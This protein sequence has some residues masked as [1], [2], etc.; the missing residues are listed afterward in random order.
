MQVL[1]R[2]VFV[3]VLLSV[4]TTSLGNAEE[5]SFGQ[6]WNALKKDFGTL[7]G[8]ITG[9][10]PAQSGGAPPAPAGADRATGE[11]IA[12]HV[13]VQVA[14]AQ[15]LLNQL[16]YSAGPVDGAYGGATR[17]AIARFQAQNGL[18]VT[19]NVTPSL[20]A[21]LQQAV[22]AGGPAVAGAGAPVAAGGPADADAGAPLPG[23]SAGAAD[24]PRYDG[25]WVR[26]V[27]S[28]LTSLGYQPGPV[29]GQFGSRT[30]DAVAAFQRAAGLAADGAPR[31]SLMAALRGR[32]QGSAPTP[33][34]AAAAQASFE[35]APD[36][37]YRTLL[38]LLMAGNP[39]AFDNQEFAL[40]YT[41]LQLPPSRDRQCQQF[42]NALANEISRQGLIAEARARLQEALAAAAQAPDD[43]VFRIV[44]SERAGEYE[45]ERGGFPIVA[46]PSSSFGGNWRLHAQP[47]SA[48]C[49][50]SAGRNFFGAY[51]NHRIEVPI[52]LASAEPLLAM[53][54]DRAQAFLDRN[55]VRS[56]QVEWLIEVAAGSGGLSG[57]AV[58]ARARDSRSAAILHEFDPALLQPAGGEPAA[59]A[60]LAPRLTSWAAAQHALRGLPELLDREQ[61]IELTRIQ[62]IADQQALE[63]GYSSG[64]RD[65]I[66]VFVAEQIQGRLPELAAEDLASTYRQY[67]LQLAAD[68]PNRLR[69]EHGLGQLVYDSAAGMLRCCGSYRQ[70]SLELLL[71]L[72]AGGGVPHG[73]PAA[74]AERALYQ[75]GR[76]IQD[77]NQGPSVGIRNGI[78]RG[79]LP[80]VSML[81][82][83]R[84]LELPGIPLERDRAE[85][86]LLELR[87]GHSSGA[88]DAV[89]EFTIEDVRRDR[90]WQPGVTPLGALAVRLDRVI[91]RMPDGRE[92]ARF[93][94]E[95]FPLARP[96]EAAVAAASP[97]AAPAPAVKS[98]PTQRVEGPAAQEGA[99]AAAASAGSWPPGAAFGVVSRAGED[100]MT[101]LA[102]VK[103]GLD[104]ATAQEI[105]NER[106][107]RVVPLPENEAVR[108]VEL[109]RS[110]GLLVSAAQFDR[111]GLAGREDLRIVPVGA[112]GAAEVGAA[113][114][115]EVAALEAPAPA[116]Q[117]D[118]RAASAFEI[119]GLT[120]G[121]AEADALAALGAEF[122][123]DQILRDEGG[124]ALA[125]ERGACG[126]A[127]PADPAL[128]QETGSFCVTLQIAEG[129][130]AGVVLRQ[131]VAADVAAPALAA[132]RER[133]G[134]PV[135]VDESA[136]APGVS[137]TVLGW[138]A[139]ANAPRIE[140][141]RVDL[142]APATVLEANVWSAHGVTLAVLRLD[143]AQEAAPEPPVAQGIKF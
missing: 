103:N 99:A 98:P 85:Q 22:A 31:P 11:A 138:G 130:V 69:A 24:E 51:S 100:A 23:A 106:G 16:G 5:F 15:D 88:L 101:A 136:P 113:V 66:P 6:A 61:L 21:A 95:A 42:G 81:A 45:F 12:N 65:A 49:R 96:A 34:V 139:P 129:V 73:T 62:V 117:P 48:V 118:E 78:Q 127:E 38:A 86:L 140:L 36:P 13:P 80:G 60:S 14:R 67:L 110:Y 58:A 124:A 17:T 32:T 41:S 37:D 29:D 87:K 134:E 54:P 52:P 104:P 9:D 64:S 18:P 132:L 107:L 120:V 70:E 89:V 137:R 109:L 91:I 135:L 57:R 43:R 114:A 68:A 121:M 8:T 46:D 53:A 59:V 71:P 33:A 97:G 119:L 125:A 56:F 3:A 123:A 25:E 39:E 131:V 141:A 2:S 47:G 7:K 55:P 1:L 84:R 63:P 90:P 126:R 50:V 77:D 40:Y 93:E 128:A 72:R 74:V 111:L 75:I 105:A 28:R 133:Y 112:A 76:N 82:F 83:D 20:I 108:A 35:T 44:S 19:G 10:R 30:A 116:P 142:E 94:P 102:F 115:A 4:S 27:Q 79:Y 122:P 92:V 26:E 143:R